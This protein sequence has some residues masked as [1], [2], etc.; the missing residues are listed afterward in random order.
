MLFLLVTFLIIGVE[1]DTNVLEIREPTIRDWTLAM[2]QYLIE[3][4]LNQLRKGN[5]TRNTFSRQAWK[6]ML[7]LFNA[8]FTTQYRKSYLRHQYKKLFKYYTGLRSLLEHKGFSWDDKQCIIV[9]DDSVWDE[10]TKVCYLS[11]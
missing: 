4:M 1:I 3:L 10:Y 11:I 5:T 6:D 9:A 2:D 8:K 7:M